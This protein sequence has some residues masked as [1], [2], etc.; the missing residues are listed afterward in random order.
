VHDGHIYALCVNCVHVNFF[1]VYLIVPQSVITILQIHLQAEMQRPYFI[2]PI[3]LI[4]TQ[5]VPCDGQ[6]RSAHCF[7][8]LPRAEINT[9]QMNVLQLILSFYSPCWRKMLKMVSFGLLIRVAPNRHS[10]LHM[11][12]LLVK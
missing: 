2:W 12:V 7:F 3:P 11:E 1:K 9:F 4:T 6:Q 8:G 10:W 5:K